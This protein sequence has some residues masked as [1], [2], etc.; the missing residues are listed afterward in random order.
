V[1]DI[2]D[3]RARYQQAV[4]FLERGRRLFAANEAVARG[5]GGVTAASVATGIARSTITRGIK[6]LR[7]GRNEIGDRV[8][9]A[10]G[11]GRK[12]AVTHQPG[13]SAALEAL[14]EDAR[15]AAIR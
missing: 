8:R 12:S 10:G 7:A 2:D 13:L 3:I 9:R 15:S 6:E 5:H 1:V 11:G 4:E 14:I